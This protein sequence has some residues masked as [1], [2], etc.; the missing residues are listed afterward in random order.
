MFALWKVVKRTSFVRPADADLMTG[1]KE[2]DEECEHW[3]AGGIE[4]NEKQRLAQMKFGRR[5]WERC[6]S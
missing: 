1:K 3:E 2:V 4:E 6:W 5:C